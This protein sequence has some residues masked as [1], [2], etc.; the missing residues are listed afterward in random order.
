MNNAHAHFV[1]RIRQALN[2]SLKDVPPTAQRR[3]EAARHLALQ[4][5]K[6]SQPVLALAT[7]GKGIG[8]SPRE[9]GDHTPFVRQ[10]LAI[11]AL[12]TGMWLSFYWHSVQYVS[13]IEAVDSALLSD[14]L[15]PEAFLDNDIFEWLKSDDDSLD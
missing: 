14:D 15:P 2:H 8:N 10:I 7:A 9:H 3:L 5:Q 12:L 11:L 6:Q 13:E 1:S 4:K